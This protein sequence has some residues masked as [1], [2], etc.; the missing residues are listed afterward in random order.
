MAPVGHRP[1][2][3]SVAEVMIYGIVGLHG[4]D[5]VRPDD[6]LEPDQFKEEP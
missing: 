4:W 1:R 6:R 2:A 3:R 5:A